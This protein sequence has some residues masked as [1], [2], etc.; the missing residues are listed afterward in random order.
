MIEARPA[1]RNAKRNMN[2]DTRMLLT[3]WRKI[4][5]GGRE[6]RERIVTR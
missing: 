4:I 2:T 3:A 5:G 1:E 6:Q